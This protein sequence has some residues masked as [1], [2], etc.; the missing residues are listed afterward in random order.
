MRTKLFIL[1][2][3]AT[4]LLG[5]SMSVQAQDD[6]PYCTAT[7]ILQPV[8]GGLPLTT[9][10]DWWHY[11]I[12]DFELVYVGDT[13]MI[14]GYHKNTNNE[15]WYKLYRPNLTEQ[16]WVQGYTGDGTYHW[17]VRFEH[18]CVLHLAGAPP[19]DR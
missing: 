7:I 4:V 3:V 10:P 18:Y 1:F 19:H 8:V 14:E 9:G 5:A 2:I 15:I 13:L 11:K 12:K 17:Q 6:P 16:R